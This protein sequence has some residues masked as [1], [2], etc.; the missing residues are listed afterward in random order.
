MCTNNK[1]QH[2]LQTRTHSQ[3]TSGVPEGPTHTGWE[4]WGDILSEVCN[5]QWGVLYVGETVRPLSVR[6]K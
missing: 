5:M 2:A 3:R 4:M 1:Y 6:T